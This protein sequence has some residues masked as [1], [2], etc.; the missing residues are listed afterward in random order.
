MVKQ[1]SNMVEIDFLRHD[2]D[3]GLGR[4]ELAIDIVTEHLDDAAGLVD[5]RGDDADGRGLAGA[6]RPQQGEEI[7]LVDL[8]I[9][10][11]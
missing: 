11:L 1:V 9:D 4:L 6:V 2:A 8:E 10:G 5:Q 3:A 7:A